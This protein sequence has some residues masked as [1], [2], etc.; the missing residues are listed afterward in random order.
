VHSETFKFLGGLNRADS[1]IIDD[2]NENNAEQ[3]L[4]KKKMKAV[5]IY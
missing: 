3:I 5:I 1:K 4:T 2:T